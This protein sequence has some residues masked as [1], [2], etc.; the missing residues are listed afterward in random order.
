V[1]GR[2][3]IVRIIGLRRHLQPDVVAM[4]LSV[5]N[6]FQVI[7]PQENVRQ[8]VEYP[9]QQRLRCCIQVDD[10]TG[11]G[12]N[13]FHGGSGEHEM[14]GLESLKDFNLLFLRNFFAAVYLAK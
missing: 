10:Q 8:T 11:P 6:V 9:R 4:Y 2:R 13:F 1:I 12:G 5:V 3:M 14:Y 7:L